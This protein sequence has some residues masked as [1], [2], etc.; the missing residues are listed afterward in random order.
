MSLNFGTLLHSRW[1][2]AAAYTV[3][4][5]K[6]KKSEKCLLEI[7]AFICKIS[8][9][10]EKLVILFFLNWNSLGFSVPPNHCGFLLLPHPSGHTRLIKE[11]F[12]FNGEESQPIP[13][14]FCPS[15]VLYG[16]SY[17]Y[18]PPRAGGPTTT[19]SKA[20]ATYWPPVVGLYFLWWN[21]VPFLAQIPSWCVSTLLTVF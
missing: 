5:Y 17:Q 20:V 1:N 3:I 9:Q 18:R 6:K 13:Q 21:D 14:L 12:L 19:R 2:M 8:I 4:V 15:W 10:W 16:R 11:Y 7:V